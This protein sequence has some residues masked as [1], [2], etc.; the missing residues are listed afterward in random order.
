MRNKKIRI[1]ICYDFDGTLAPGNMQ[2][3]SLLPALNLRPKIFWGEVKD[4]A[5]EKKMNEILAYMYLTIDKA[6]NANHQ[7]KRASFRKHGNQ[8]QLFKGVDKYFDLINKYAESKN[9][10]IEHYIISSGLKEIIEG[11]RIRNK[12]KFIFASEFFYDINGVA[13]WPALAID[14]TNKTQYLFRINKGIMNVWDNTKI[15]KYV[16]EEERYIPFKRMIYIGDGETDIPSMKMVN[17]QGGYSIAVY[18]PN[19]RHTKTKKSPKE[20]CEELLEHGRARYIAPAKYS[21]NSKLVSLI[22][23]IIDKILIEES[24][25]KTLPTKYKKLKHIN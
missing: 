12:F 9:I 8:I 5:K 18:D 13:Q 21:K 24:L 10:A 25:I 17:F 19:K 15:N 6:K 3:H 7:I 2:E 4:F 23:L 1:A 14:Y 16:P 11:T 22:K 20:I